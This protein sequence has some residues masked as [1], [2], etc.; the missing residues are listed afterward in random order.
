MIKRGLVKGFLIE[1]LSRIVE[2]LEE[3]WSRIVELS[4]ESWSR[5]VNHWRSRVVDLEER[6]I[7]SASTGN[8]TR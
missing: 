2:L 7:T 5:V 3:S 8:N 4:E 6:R 1:S